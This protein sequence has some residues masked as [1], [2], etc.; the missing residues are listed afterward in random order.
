[1]VA[2]HTHSPENGSIA[3]FFLFLIFKCAVF[4]CVNQCVAV[5]V[6]VYNSLVRFTSFFFFAVASNTQN[7]ETLPFFM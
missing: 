2:E 6:C 5:C 1:M 7:N 3:F 4:A